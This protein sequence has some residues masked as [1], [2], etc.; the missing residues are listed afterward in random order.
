MKR[1]INIK[2]VTNFGLSN[3]GFLR[4][5]N[6]SSEMALSILIKEDKLRKDAKTFRERNKGRVV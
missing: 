2:G 5:K 4:N 3:Y 1:N 6:I